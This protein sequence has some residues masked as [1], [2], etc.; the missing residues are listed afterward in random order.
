MSRPAPRSANEGRR[1]GSATSPRDSSIS[2][3][4]GTTSAARDCRLIATIPNTAAKTETYS[5]VAGIVS[6]R[7]QGTSK[8]MS[9]RRA[10]LDEP[11][12]G[13]LDSVLRTAA[14]PTA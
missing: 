14:A 9:L 4:A 12:P 10:E 11:F 13:L 5:P 7:E 8:Y 3:K 6:E 2:S 1:G